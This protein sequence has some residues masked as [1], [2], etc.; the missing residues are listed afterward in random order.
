MNQAVVC[1]GDS[2][3][4]WG[5]RS[6]GWVS[7]LSEL[8]GGRFDVLNR[9]V[10]GYTASLVTRHVLPPSTVLLSSGPLLLRCVI[11]CIGANDA[12][13][14]PS[15][16]HVPLPQFRLDF[17]HLLHQIIS[18]FPLC[19]ILCCSPPPVNDAQYEPKTRLSSVTRQY[20][21]V[22]QEV[23]DQHQER[24][25]IHFIDMFDAFHSSNV[26]MDT[27]FSDGLHLSPQGNLVFFSAVQSK[28]KLLGLADQ[29]PMAFPSWRECLGVAI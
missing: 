20:A 17:A 2:L 24:D 13:I 27:L 14:P 12:A 18:Q 3:T 16:Q 7:L 25:R 8:G 19:P 1:F 9:G 6:G 11:L 15:P 22:C 21:A 28:L 29:G 5:G 23:C 26:A 4:Q 10:S